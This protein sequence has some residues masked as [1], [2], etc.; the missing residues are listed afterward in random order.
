MVDCEHAAGWSD[1]LGQARVARPRL[2]GRLM[3]GHVG[4]V[5]AA[6][7]YGKSTLTSEWAEWLGGATVAVPI[8]PGERNP[9][10]FVA[11]LRRSLRAARLSGLAAV[12]GPTEAPAQIDRLVDALGETSAPVLFVLDD[13]HRLDGAAADLAVQLA[14]ELPAPHH[15]VVAARRLPPSLEPL[16]LAPGVVCL[17]TAD[18]AFTVEEV[19]ELCRQQFGVDAPDDYVAHLEVTS[20]GWATALVLETN[21]QRTIGVP[22][23]PVPTHSTGAVHV[24]KLIDALLGS[25]PTRH[26]Q[27]LV[28]LAHV[29][30]LSPEVIDEIAG[31]RRVMERLVELGVP[32]ARSP[33]GWWELPGPLVDNLRIRAPLAVETARAAAA[34]YVRHQAVPV[35]VR[36]LSS[37]ASVDEAGA[38]VAGL[39]PRLADDL[40]TDV[41][42]ALA[43]SL[44]AETTAAH[45]RILLHVA[46]TAEAS[47]RNDRRTAALARLQSLL[48]SAGDDADPVIGRELETELA[49]DMMWDQRTFAQA[50]TLASSVLARA[51]AAEIVT[52]ARALDV[53]GRLASWFSME[54]PQPRAVALLEESARLSR[55]IAQPTWAAQA[56]V[57][58][59]MGYY[60]DSG[61]LARSLETLDNVLAELSERSSYA[62]MVHSFRVDCLAELGR[63]DEAEAAIQRM[64]AIGLARRQEWI[65]AYAS[66]GEATLASFAGDAPRTVAALADVESHRAEWFDQTSGVEFLV[67]A[68]DLADRVGEHTV[69][70]HYLQRAQAR[71]D[72]AEAIVS[73]LEAMVIG[74]SGDPETAEA[75]T[76]A[77]LARPDLKP[78]DRWP[79]ALIRAHAALRRGLPD[80]PRLAVEAFD[81]CMVLGSEAR[82]VIRLREPAAYAAVLP[83][84]LE[85]GSRAA[86]IISK[87]RD[88]LSVRVLGTFAVLR[89]GQPVD[90]PDGMPAAAVR[91]VA[92]MGGRCRADW[93]IS[94][95]WPAAEIASGRNRLRNLLSR[96]R[97]PGGQIL[98]RDG[99]HIALPEGC[100]VDAVC[101]E[102][103]AHEVL[104]AVGQGDAGPPWLASAREALELYRGDLLA[105]DAETSSFYERRQ[106]L[107]TLYLELLDLVG[108]DAERRGDVDE[109][110]RL[111]RRAIEVERYDEDRYLTLAN[112][113]VSQGRVGSARRAIDQARA[114]L[115]ELGL[116]LSW[117]LERLE[118]FL[119]SE[120]SSEPA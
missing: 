45:P 92:G 62:A 87:G 111:V 100:E 30:L 103:R 94:H 93:L 89:N 86:A 38:L 118:L 58:L 88:Q 39:E 20:G 33:S 104:S 68:A 52:R 4:L 35:A 73:V 91:A 16:R 60:H 85:A 41:L 70:R 44:P 3:G 71:R 75:L 48:A 11:S 43:D 96:L 102:R 109:A 81:A 46:R 47:H 8:G 56:L 26:R 18:L 19:A 65:L 37:T 107:R 29:P 49:R 101:F 120:R 1:E 84:A 113:L 32:L 79:L 105:D 42:W 9:A 116:D 14:R 69:A 76:A 115:D 90:V 50:E 97:D 108:A 77:A 99:D 112:L 61:D 10:L 17:E 80:A 13:A 2:L 55:S 53:L 110:V 63:V 31:D 28:Q 106:R 98:L 72:G 24:T 64:R 27:L 23:G 57:A 22:S 74:R 6:A 7:G 40:G 82:T 12:V 67:V 117:P 114:A 25:L 59:A 15:L 66:W 83:V 54:G 78:H 5:E 119:G 21:A 95:L 51:G 34:V 36:L